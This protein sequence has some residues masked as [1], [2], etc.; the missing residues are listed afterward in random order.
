[1]TDA[2]IGY[3]SK[4]EISNGDGPETFYELEEVFLIEPGEE[5]TDWIQATHYQS[6]GRRHEYLAGITDVGEGTIQFNFIPGSPTHQF[7]RDLRNS[8]EKRTHRITHPNGVTVSY[9]AIVGSVSRAMPLDDRMTATATI[10]VSGDETWENEP[11][12]E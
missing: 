8:G 12:I 2:M 10:R 4:Y 5:T 3:N 7:M 9:E 1:M 11:E 6:P